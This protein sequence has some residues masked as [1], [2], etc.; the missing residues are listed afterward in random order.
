MAKT[1][2]VQLVVTTHESLLLNLKLLRRDEIF[3][4]EKNKEGA[5]VIYPFDQFQEQFDAQLEQAYLTGRYGGVPF[6]E[7]LYLP[8]ED[9]V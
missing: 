3:F 9:E 6:F 1:K 8:G 7:S 5:S 4:V 2:N